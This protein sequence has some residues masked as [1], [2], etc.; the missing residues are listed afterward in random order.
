M[1]LGLI[2]QKTAVKPSSVFPQKT[3]KNQHVNVC[4]AKSKIEYSVLVMGVIMP[5][6]PSCGN[7][8]EPE[9]LFCTNCGA[10][11]GSKLREPSVLL[12]G[13]ILLDKTHYESLGSIAFSEDTLVE[14]AE[15]LGYQVRVLDCSWKDHCFEY[16]TLYRGVKGVIIGGIEKWEKVSEKEKANLKDYVRSGGT[17]FIT[18]ASHVLMGDSTVGLNK[19]SRAFGIKF[20]KKKAKDEKHHEG[21]HSDHVLIHNFVQHPL[22]RDLGMISFYDHGGMTIKLKNPA[23]QALAFTD[24]DANPPNQPV[25]VVV[26]YGKGRVVAFSCSSLFSSLGL[27]KNDN[28]K[29]ARNI[30]SFFTVALSPPPPI[31]EAT[32]IIET[33]VVKITTAGDVMHRFDIAMHLQRLKNNFPMKLQDQF[34]Q[35]YLEMVRFSIMPCSYT[36]FFETGEERLKTYQQTGMLGALSRKQ[37]YV[38]IKDRHPI[39]LD[40]EQLSSLGDYLLE[41]KEI[42]E[43]HLGKFYYTGRRFIL[44]TEESEI[45]IY[46]EIGETPPKPG[47]PMFSLWIKPDFQ[48]FYRL[49]GLDGWEE[50]LLS[51][52]KYTSMRLEVG[53]IKNAIMEMDWIMEGPKDTK[54]ESKLTLAKTIAGKD[55]LKL[56]DASQHIRQLIAQSTPTNVVD[57]LKYYNACKTIPGAM[58]QTRLG[59]SKPASEMNSDYKI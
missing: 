52:K 40:D 41:F 3:A 18:C 33:Q 11:M 24:D 34:P 21:R 12:S 56:E 26:P 48:E 50:G 19:F 8:N 45:S 51:K 7:K 22:T 30:L 54:S 32:P 47:R 20:S 36:Y 28:R 49:I 37:E 53:K 2:P 39:L 4:I 31:A 14:I 44:D 17:L 55:Y 10:K 43:K 15:E 59:P 42:N 23:A 46:Y 1:H 35:K 13:T 6:C 9:F 38:K 25:L 16:S 29:L 5:V 58:G 57:I 27:D